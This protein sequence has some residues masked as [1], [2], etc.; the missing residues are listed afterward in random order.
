VSTDL[1]KV[2][3]VLGVEFGTKSLLYEALTHRSY[4]NE[5]PG[6]EYSHNERLEYLGDAVLELITTEFLFANYKDYSEGQ[7]TAIRAALVN[8]QFLAKVAKEMNLDEFIFVS[9]GEAQDTGKAKE[10]ILANTFE[11]VLGAIYLDK[12]Y[13]ISAKF[14]KEKVLVSTAEI[15]EKGLYRDPKSLLQE[16]IQDRLRVTPTYNVLSESGPD[17]QKV[18]K[19]GVYFNED[20][21]TEGEGLSKQEAEIKAAEK[22]LEKIVADNSA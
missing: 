17:H 16:I 10:V 12:G 14:V 21:I 2:E 11:S 1:S 18:F 7:L 15:I 19:V 3:K 4:L 20:L 6:W 5:N 13:D 9:K 8:Y 22:A